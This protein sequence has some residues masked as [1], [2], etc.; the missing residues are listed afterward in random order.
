MQETA[1]KTQKQTEDVSMLRARVVKL[2]REVSTL[3]GQ[4]EKYRSRAHASERSLQSLKSK[5]T[6]LLDQVQVRGG[7]AKEREV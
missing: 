3:T 6:D 2:E 7:R 1:A 4:A 5:D